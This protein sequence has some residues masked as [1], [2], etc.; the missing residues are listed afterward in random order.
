MLLGKIGDEVYEADA[1]EAQAKKDFIAFETASTESKEAMEESVT[2]LQG[3]EAT[4]LGK[5]GDHE[6]VKGTTQGELDSTH[7]YLDR[8]APNCDWIRGAFYSRLK[9]RKAE[10]EGLTDAKSLLS[11]G[12][13]VTMAV[14][15][16]AAL[17]VHTA[18]TDQLL[19]SLDGDYKKWS[20]KA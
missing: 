17:N 18:T 5:I 16:S 11:G 19:D 2:T 1:A 20:G 8:I 7:E 10:M 9:R 6:D 3:T 13:P 14:V 15:K 12:S 4:N